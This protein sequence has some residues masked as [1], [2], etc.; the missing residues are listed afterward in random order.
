MQRHFLLIF[1]SEG[2]YHLDSDLSLAGSRHHH[3]FSS[4][5]GN[6]PRAVVETSVCALVPRDLE[7]LVV[8]VF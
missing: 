6:H 2:V 4:G 8:M 5:I 3:P 7:V 1:L